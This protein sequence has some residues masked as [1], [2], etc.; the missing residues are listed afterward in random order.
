MRVR[1]LLCSLLLITT[2]AAFCPVRAQSLADVA[3]QEGERRKEA[4]T[5][6]KTLTNQDLPNAP[7]PTSAPPPSAADAAK[8]AD[9]TKADASTGDAKAGDK[10]GDKTVDKSKPEYWAGT[11]KGLQSKL[12]EDQI[13]ADALQSRIN[14]LT[15]DFVNRDDP[16]QRATIAQDKQKAL[17]ELT[18]LKTSVVADAKAISDFEEDARKAGVPPGWLR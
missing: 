5:Q 7:P 16:A 17:D 11:M 1:A 8:S 9:K 13:L 4:G 2:G 14:A 3:R 15:T 12:Q 10:A 18:T 6:T